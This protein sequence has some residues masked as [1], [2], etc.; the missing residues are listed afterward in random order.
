[1]PS[2]PEETGLA[3]AAL[4][5]DPDAG[6]VVRGGI[7]RLEAFFAGTAF[8]EARPIGLYF[9]S[10]W[11]YE[12]LYPLIFAVAGLRRCLAAREA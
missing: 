8:P 3:L 12:K 11:Y 7:A 2:G 5:N 6:E 1:M 4:A 10:L 9:A